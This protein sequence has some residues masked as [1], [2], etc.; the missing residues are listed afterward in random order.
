MLLA[1]TDGLAESRTLTLDTGIA[2]LAADL[3]AFDS[4]SDLDSLADMML[5]HAD[6][7]DDTALVLLRWSL[8][9]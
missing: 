4:D 5:A 2:Q 8:H 6:S 1:Y 7:I 3:A 9:P